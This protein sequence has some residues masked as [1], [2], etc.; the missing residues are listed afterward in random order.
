[1]PKLCFQHPNPFQIEQQTLSFVA[2]LEK[3]IICIAQPSM[4]YV[5]DYAYHIIPCT[6]GA[7]VVMAAVGAVAAETAVGGSIRS[8]GSNRQATGSSVAWG[9]SVGSSF[10]I[11]SGGTQSTL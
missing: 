7:A 8:R 6:R 3:S 1:M 2:S 9:V 10:Q 4:D 11:Q 5:C